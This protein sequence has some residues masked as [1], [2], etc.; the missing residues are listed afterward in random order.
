MHP[1]FANIL[2]Y[3][4][5]EKSETIQYW[6]K[7]KTWVTRHRASEF[8]RFRWILVRPEQRFPDK[9]FEQPAKVAL[10]YYVPFAIDRVQADR[11]VTT[12]RVLRFRRSRPVTICARH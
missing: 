7:Y 2:I 4:L 1:I 9:K 6:C 10:F 11:T 8:F 3:F 5:C 12:A